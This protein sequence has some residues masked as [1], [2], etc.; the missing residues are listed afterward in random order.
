VTLSATGFEL[1]QLL[2]QRPF[3]VLDTEY[4]ADP[5]GDGDRLISVAVA[6]VV[7]RKRVRDG[8][9]YREMNPGVPVSAASTR[10][11]GF[12]TEAVAGKRPFRHHAPAILA[13]LR[14]P[15]AVLPSPAGGPGQRQP[16]PADLTVRGGSCR[17][18]EP[19]PAPVSS[20]G[21]ARVPVAPA[22]RIDSPGGAPVQCFAARAGHP[23]HHAR[24]R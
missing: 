10:V 15:D 13:A 6:R 17:L 21:P 12:T 14:V 3:V 8:E 19:G 22:C 1:F 7:R 16:L 23:H 24:H 11:H 4:T 9:L 2:T 18:C 20:A 5:D